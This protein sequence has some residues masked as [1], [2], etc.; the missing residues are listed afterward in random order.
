MPD[1]PVAQIDYRS[2][3][4]TDQEEHRVGYYPGAVIADKKS[5]NFDK[6]RFDVHM[7]LADFARS[8]REA[9]RQYEFKM[10][11]IAYAALAAL[12]IYPKTKTPV[13]V[14]LIVVLTIWIIHTLWVYR[15]FR[16]NEYGRMQM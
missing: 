9:R 2:A 10:P 11:A 7:Q 13:Y 4:V 12:S 5:D 8:I 3:A 15:N 16:S 1:E 6:D 14:I